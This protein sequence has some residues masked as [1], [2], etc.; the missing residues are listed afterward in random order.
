MLCLARSD[1]PFQED[2]LPENL[3][4]IA[5]VVLSDTIRREAPGTFKFFA[6][7]GV[8]LKVISGDDPLTVAT[9]AGKAGIAGAERYVDMSNQPEDG[10]FTRLVEENAV[11][12]RVSPR[13]KQGLLRA[14][15]EN[16][17]TTC[18]TGDG[19]NDV[20]A[21]K[22]SDC[23]VAMIAGSDAARGASD[24]VLM[25][26]DFSAMIGVLREGRRVIN[27]IEM[28]SALYLV[29]TIYSTLLSLLYIFLPYPYPFAPLQ[30]TPI[31]SLT[32]GIPSFFLALRANYQRP[33]GKFLAGILER[34]VPAALTV[35]FNILVIQ[36]AGIF[37]ELPF[38]QTATMNVFLTGA[39]GFV[40]L[41]RVSRPLT[42][43]FKGMLIALSGAFILLFLFLGQFFMLESLLT[44]NVFFYLPLLYVSP[45]MFRFL[46]RLVRKLEK[47]WAKRKEKRRLRIP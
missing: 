10:N 21:M 5:L 41:S 29:K 17:H 30:M 32:V 14:L 20:L 44:R 11:F 34:S 31:N 8:T 42:G 13:Q 33:E 40:L 36:L 1:G 12:G 39:V 26:S 35:V 7:E 28:V 37:F 22:E 9:I 3:R 4:C 2:R 27:N 23:S 19:V 45:R 24:F 15:R 43:R 47:W 38:A 25:S 46:G 16:G 18:M 6:G